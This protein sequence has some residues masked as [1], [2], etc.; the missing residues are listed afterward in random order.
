MFHSSPEAFQMIGI[1]KGNLNWLSIGGIEYF[2][3]FFVIEALV[4]HSHNIRLSWL[5]E[6]L[7]SDLILISE[8]L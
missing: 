4:D 2:S 8:Y 5:L 6:V 3:L 7:V 1:S